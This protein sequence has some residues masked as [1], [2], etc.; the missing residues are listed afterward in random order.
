MDHPNIIRMYEF[1][2]DEN[3]FYMITEICN[4]GEVFEEI[5]SRKRFTE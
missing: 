2:E 1:F 4:G 5:V 3:N